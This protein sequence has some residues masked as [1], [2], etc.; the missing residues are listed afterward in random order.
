MKAGRDAVVV[1]LSSACDF[2]YVINWEYFEY[3]A[4]AW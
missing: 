1:T 3:L 2:W 4:F